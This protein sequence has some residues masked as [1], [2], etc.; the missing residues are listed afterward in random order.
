MKTLAINGGNPIRKISLP[1]YQVFNEEEAKCAY[2]VVKSGILSDYLG[3]WDSAFYGG[4]QVQA[5][6][7]EWADYFKSKHAVSV[8]S[9]TSGIITA[10][11]AVG[12][13]PGDEVIVSP[14]S[15]SISASAPIF[16][17]ALPVFADIE[18]DYFCLNPDDIERKITPRTKAI[19][20]V[21]IFGQPFNVERIKE[22]AK[23]NNLYIIEDCAQAPGA[24]YNNEFAGTLGDI[25]IFSL[26]YHKHIHTGEGGMIITDDDDL[27]VRCQLIR[28]HAETVVDDMGYQGSP[29]NMVGMNL[30][31][32]EIEAGIGRIQL[33]KLDGLLKKR[34]NN[35]R[36]LEEGLSDLP[37]LTMPKIR[38][39]AEHAYYIHVMK[40][41]ETSTG[42]SRAD[43]VD[44]VN[45][46]L[47]P[48]GKNDTR[49]SML[50]CGYVKPLYLQSLYQNKTGIGKACYPFTNPVYEDVSYTKGLCPVTE[51]MH[52]EKVIINDLIHASLTES[53]MK[54]IIDAFHKV[55]DNLDELKQQV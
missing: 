53:D 16:W 28:N 1:S 3:C 13:G 32:T 4:E 51:E 37:F 11:G 6:E 44:A 40:Y 48:A 52:F 19:I 15:M 8:N 5:F 43:F 31:M 50:S 12:V 29:V 39:S 17:G 10:L 36:M 7:K 24:K 55:T 2:Y 38:D 54:D 47:M 34:L 35:V 14:Y 9:N 20:V 41:D 21:D 45:Y 30:R 33:S 49:N 26:N 46:E 27:A 23:K 22:I 25:G 42:V 18:P